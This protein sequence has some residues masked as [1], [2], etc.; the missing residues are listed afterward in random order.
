MKVWLDDMRAAPVGWIRAH[1]ASQCIELLQDHGDVITHVSL[2]HDLGGGPYKERSHED[3]LSGMDV[4]KWLEQNGKW[5][6]HV[7]VHSLNI[8]RAKQMAER[9]SQHTVAEFRPFSWL[10]DDDG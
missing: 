2:D 5:P 3:G 6:P 1:T 8:Y 9:A 4:I 10:E 7:R